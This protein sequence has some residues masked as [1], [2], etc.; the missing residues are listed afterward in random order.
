MVCS[1]FLPVISCCF[2]GCSILRSNY[3]LSKVISMEMFVVGLTDDLI[4]DL[5]H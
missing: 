1:L 3:S 4:V 5:I 2:F